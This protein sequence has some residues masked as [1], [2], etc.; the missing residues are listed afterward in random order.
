MYIVV[1]FDRGIGDI[2]H[3]VVTVIVVSIILIEICYGLFA[4]EASAND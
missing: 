1:F 3:L 4:K 2:S